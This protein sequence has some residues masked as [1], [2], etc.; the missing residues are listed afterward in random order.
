M[1]NDPVVAADG[2]TYERSSIEDWF[3]KSKARGGGIYSPVHGTEIKS[4]ILTPNISVR[5]MA[6]AFKDEK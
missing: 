6:R 4:L 1:T 2:I 3:K 5:N